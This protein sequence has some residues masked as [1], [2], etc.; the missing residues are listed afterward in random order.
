MINVSI[1]GYATC[2]VA[3]IILTF[4]LAVSA[5]DSWQGRSALLASFV[6]SLW[7]IFSAFQASSE[8]L[9]NIYLSILELLR[10]GTWLLFLVM[11]LVNAG[12]SGEV[13]KSLILVGKIVLSVLFFLCLYMLIY[14]LVDF[15]FTNVIDFTWF[16]FIK[17]I[18]AIVGLIFIEQ[19]FRNTRLENRWAVKFLFFGIGG[20]FTYDFYL[21]AD[22]LLFN[23]IERC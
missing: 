10:D 5:R 22:A 18:V 1:I 11:M 20:I 2:A 7:A 15:S 19:L 16:T 4:L 3:F 8:Y 6:T 12:V 17:L 23:R 13:K 14:T 9:D 21:Y